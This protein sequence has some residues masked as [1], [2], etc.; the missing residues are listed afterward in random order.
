MSSRFAYDAARGNNNEARCSDPSG[1]RR[2]GLA[3]H[4]RAAPITAWIRRHDGDD[5]GLDII[6]AAMVREAGLA[7]VAMT[8][9]SEAERRRTLEAAPPHISQ[10]VCLSPLT[11]AVDRVLGVF[12]QARRRIKLLV[13]AP[14]Q[15]SD[16][17]TE[18][19]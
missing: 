12:R 6:R 7:V 17:T 19:H 15:R 11:T 4:R 3:R 2:T 8:F 9:A 10:S 1:G 16:A 13:G 14:P 18:S 5:A